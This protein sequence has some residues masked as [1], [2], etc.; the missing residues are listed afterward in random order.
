MHSYTVMF[1]PYLFQLAE[2]YRMKQ[3]YTQERMAACLH[4]TARNYNRLKNEEYTFSAAALV[5]LL[6]LLSD[7]EV[8]QFLRAMRNVTAQEPYNS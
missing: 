4:M 5:L 7:D 3:R 8:L 6:A 2:Q 1:R